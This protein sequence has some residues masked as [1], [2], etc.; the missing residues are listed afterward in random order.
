LRSKGP[1]QVDPKFSYIILDIDFF[2]NINEIHGHDAGDY[3]I[4]A[5]GG[6]LGKIPDVFAARL[7]GEEFVLLARNYPDYPSHLAGANMR[8]QAS[9]LV[10]G[11]TIADQIR[12]RIESNQFVYQKGPQKI[13]LKI[14]ASFG[15]SGYDFGGYD[16][17]DHEFGE[18]VHKT[19]DS[20]S[21]VYRRADK[22]L[23]YA[24]LHGRNQVKTYAFAKDI[25]ATSSKKHGLWD[26][27]KQ[28]VDVA[29]GRREVR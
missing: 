5:I 9:Q 20:E 3:A 8:A 1:S 24:K 25:G 11:G 7:G 13:P 12:R 23:N 27:I 17:F 10:T 15:V 26:R 4:Q 2:K 19:A 16:Y 28:G 14:T 6:L 22:A 29:R 18:K 21:D